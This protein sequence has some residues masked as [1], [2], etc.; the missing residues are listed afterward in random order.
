MIYVT[1]DNK[2]A[3]VAPGSAGNFTFYLMEAD[4]PRRKGKRVRGRSESLWFESQEAAE[5]ALASYAKKRG[6]VKQ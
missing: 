6:W 3:Y 5:L 1:K 2:L 4:N